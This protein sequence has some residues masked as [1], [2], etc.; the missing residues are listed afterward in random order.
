[1]LVGTLHCTH[2]ALAAGDHT[3]VLTANRAE[4]LFLQLT[5]GGCCSSVAFPRIFRILYA[6]NESTASWQWLRGIW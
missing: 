3:G 1:M 4:K 5:E 6:G 2:K